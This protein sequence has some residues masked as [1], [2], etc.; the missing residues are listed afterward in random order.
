MSDKTKP[1]SK[2]ASKPASKP[3]KPDN[4]VRLVP[5]AKPEPAPSLGP[6]HLKLLVDHLNVVLTMAVS[7]KQR[8]LDLT[9]QREAHEHE[10]RLAA[11]RAAQG[12]KA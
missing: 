11:L 5:P 9:S 8:E 12:Q 7:M 3:S 2:P 1:P 6:E 10:F 4:V